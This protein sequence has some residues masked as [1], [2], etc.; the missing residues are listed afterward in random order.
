[1]V[2]YRG[3]LSD[4]AMPEDGT[5]GHVTLLVPAEL[6]AKHARARPDA[7][8]PIACDREHIAS[9]APTTRKVLA[10]GG[11]G[12]GRGGAP[13]ATRSSASPRSAS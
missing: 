7:P 6:L 4:V 13:V 8:L 1:M 2:D 3:E 9:L 11:R 12:A 10:R 5:E